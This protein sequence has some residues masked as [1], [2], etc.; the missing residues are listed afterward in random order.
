MRNKK[1]LVTGSSGLIGS[2]VVRYFCNLGYEVYGLDNNLREQFFGPQGSTLST[3]AGLKEKFKNFTN[4][5]IDIRD[6]E[7]IRELIS[8]I[9]QLRKLNKFFSLDILV[10]INLVF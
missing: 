4:Y 8:E 5:E 2:E 6:K 10:Q 1:I 3:L 7:K 9:K